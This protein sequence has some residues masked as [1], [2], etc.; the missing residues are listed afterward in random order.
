MVASPPGAD[1]TKGPTAPGMS[2]RRWNSS[3]DTSTWPASQVQ[4]F[5]GV[6]DGN[7]SRTIPSA[8]T[9]LA[10][11]AL[12]TSDCDGSRFGNV[13]FQSRPAI[14]KE[15]LFAHRSSDTAEQKL[16]KPTACSAYHFDRTSICCP[17]CACSGGFPDAISA[18]RLETGGD[19]R[20]GSGRIAR[21]E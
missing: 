17:F 8:P 19:T 3:K 13:T 14:R 10:V 4:V 5:S 20:Q 21:R 12:A 6:S 16:P 1:A 9:R 18:T 2:A 11:V 7:C 15:P